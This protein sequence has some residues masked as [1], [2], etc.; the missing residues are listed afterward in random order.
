MA[1]STKNTL[2][3]SFSIFFILMKSKS[4]SFHQAQVRAQ[5]NH[6]F[7]FGKTTVIFRVGVQIRVRYPGYDFRGLSSLF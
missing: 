6:F 7:E 5:I 3:E 2:S 4:S 1:R